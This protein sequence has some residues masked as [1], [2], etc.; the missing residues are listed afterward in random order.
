MIKETDDGLKNRKSHFDAEF[1]ELNGEFAVPCN[2]TCYERLD[3]QTERIQACLTENWLN[4]CTP[5]SH[6]IT[7]ILHNNTINKE[8]MI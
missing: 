7:L 8:G 1:T 5:K 3:D 4:I 6:I 2:Y